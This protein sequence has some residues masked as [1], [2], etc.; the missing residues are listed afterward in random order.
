L[1]THF[2]H[3]YCVGVSWRLL[4]RSYDNLRRTVWTGCSDLKSNQ[5]VGIL[6]TLLSRLRIMN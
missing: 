6:T 1:K 5:E 3:E 2:V 4:F